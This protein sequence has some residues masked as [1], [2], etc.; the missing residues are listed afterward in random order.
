MVRSPPYRR[1]H[2]QWRLWFM[3]YALRSSI[4]FPNLTEF[5]IH[6]I[7]CDMIK[8]LC[9]CGTHRVTVSCT[10][11]ARRTLYRHRRRCCFSHFQETEF[12]YFSGIIHFAIYFFTRLGYLIISNFVPHKR[13]IMRM[14]RQWMEEIRKDECVDGNGRVRKKE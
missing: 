14:C 6:T 2:I 10:C 8:I 1:I 11:V 4:E 9:I 13:I 12:C 7:R 3:V 5:S